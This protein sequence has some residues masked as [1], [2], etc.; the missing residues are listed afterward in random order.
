MSATATKTEIPSGTWSSDPVHSSASF[1]V[2]HNGFSLFRTSFGDLDAKLTAGDTHRIEGRVAVE[3]VDVTQPDFR[4]HLLSP[5][6]FDAD[7]YPHITFTSD[8]LQ[9]DGGRATLR[10]ELTIAGKTR[11][12]EASGE[13]RGP[14]VGPTGTEVVGLSLSAEVDRNDYGIGWNMDLPNG[15][16]VLGDNVKLVVELELGKE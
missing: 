11:P 14:G 6:F 3:S 1:E 8:D 12:V 7:R 5:E 9:V 16:K 15:K 2:E 10:G 4:A 13:F